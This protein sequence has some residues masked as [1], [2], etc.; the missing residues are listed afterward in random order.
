MRLPAVGGTLVVLMA[1]AGPA[2][3]Q[4][5]QSSR[6]ATIEQAEAD[7]AG[8]LKPFAPDKAE[9]I[10]TRISDIMVASQL[11]WHP[12]W[13]SAYSGGGFTAGAGYVKAVGAYDRVDMRGSITFSGYKRLETEFVAPRLFDRRVTF[14]A[15]GGWREATEVGFYGIGRSSAQENRANYAFQQPYAGAILGARPTRGSLLLEAGFEVSEW[16]LQSAGSGSVPPVE[17]VYTPATLPGLGASPA[18]LHS[19]ATVA[20]DSRPGLGSAATVWL[21]SRPAYGYAKSGGFYGITVHDFHDTG[22]QFGFNR[23][24]YDAIQHIPIFRDT[25]VVSLH[26]HV[27]TAFGKSGQVIPF[28]M[29]PSLGGGDDLRGYS[30]WRFRDNDSM[31]MQ[32]EWRAMI[33]RFFETVIFADAGRVAARPEDLGFNGMRTDYGVGFRF[34]GPLSTPLRIDFVGGP[35]GFGIVFAAGAAF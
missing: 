26:G 13:K 23:V 21:D 4:D 19:Q 8:N 31:L 33:N 15:L 24:D 35:E 25:W 30:S 1:L 11:G 3:A 10:I 18:Y 12:F 22:A 16:K 28:F 14:A 34:H 20:F 27:E 2:H 29:L 9:Q 6:E 32:A 17:E 5:A 7:K